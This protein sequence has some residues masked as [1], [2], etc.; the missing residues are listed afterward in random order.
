M[1]ATFKK[2][3][4]KYRSLSLAKR[5]ALGAFILFGLLILFGV[6]GEAFSAVFSS[7]AN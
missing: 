1:K 3:S 2:L 5:I 6:L 4:A 7:L